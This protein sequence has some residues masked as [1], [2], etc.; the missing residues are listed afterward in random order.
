MS[1][2]TAGLSRPTWIL[3]AAL[4]WLAPPPAAAGPGQGLT[5]HQIARLR[6]VGE[7]AISPGGDRPPV[8]YV[9][10]VPRRP[11]VDEDGPPRFMKLSV[12]RFASSFMRL[13]L[14][15]RIPHF[16]MIS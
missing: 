6:A 11:L 10:E 2:A 16:M 4:L 3:L 13:L 5:V 8:A 15:Q 1:E 7:V 14:S 9:L 12:P